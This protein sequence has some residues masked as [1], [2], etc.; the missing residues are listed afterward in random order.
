MRNFLAVTLLVLA[1]SVG[2]IHKTG[3]AVTPME[4]ITTDNALF[5]QINNEV[6]QGTEA[7]VTSG[8]LTPSQAAPVIGWTG[9][10]AK[11]HEQITQILSAGST[12]DPADYQTIQ[13]LI[14]QIQS[15]ATALVN[16]GNL[17]IKNPKS[18]QTISADITAALNLAQALLTELQ[19]L[20]PTKASTGGVN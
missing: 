12:V 13:T 19:A 3:G 16:S 6:E 15:S 5:A 10:V 20:T 8:L 14:S 7:V 17:N 4:R 18:Q 11:I 2:C 1:S 9:Q